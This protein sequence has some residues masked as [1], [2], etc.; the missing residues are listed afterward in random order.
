[1][2]MLLDPRNHNPNTLLRGSGHSKQYCGI[3][4]DIPLATLPIWGVSAW[5]IP[6]F[7]VSITADG[8][9]VPIGDRIWRPSHVTR[10]GFEPD[11]GIQL[12]EQTFVDVR[13]IAICALQLRNAGDY[14]IRINVNPHWNHSHPQHPVRVSNP[15]GDDLEQ[16]LPRECRIDF[17]FAC[18]W[19]PAHTQDV[20]N[21]PAADND[22]ATRQ[23]DAFTNWYADNAPLLSSTNPWLDFAWAYGHYLRWAAPDSGHPNVPFTSVEALFDDE[24]Y[25]IPKAITPHTPDDILKSTFNVTSDAGGLSVSPITD[26]LPSAICISDILIGRNRYSFVWDSPA[27]PDDHFDDGDKGFTVYH[28]SRRIHHSDKPTAFYYPC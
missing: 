4:K 22:P 25:G 16:V 24:A 3:Y 20:I 13:G 17:V 1:M 9:Q 19:D 5:D 15:P 10:N 21:R 6:L 2:P 14:S 26:A 11:S 28:G 18:T 12:T 23:A 27:V 8:I 7:D